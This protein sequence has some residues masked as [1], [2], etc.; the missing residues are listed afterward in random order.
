MYAQLFFIIWIEK[1]Q[2]MNGHPLT[3]YIKLQ[4]IYH[5]TNSRLISWYGCFYMHAIDTYIMELLCVYEKFAR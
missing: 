2:G 4:Y 1:R 3:I 5:D